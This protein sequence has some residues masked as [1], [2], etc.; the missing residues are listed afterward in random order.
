MIQTLI[1]SIVICVL[2]LD[3]CPIIGFPC[4]LHI[5][6]K[7]KG[8]KGIPQSFTLCKVLIFQSGFFYINL[9]TT[10]HFSRRIMIKCC[11]E[12]NFPRRHFFLLTPE[13]SVIYWLATDRPLTNS[14]SIFLSSSILCEILI[15]MM[16]K[17]F[18]KCL[19]FILCLP[20]PPLR[21]PAGSKVKSALSSLFHNFSDF[22]NFLRFPKY[23]IHT[24]IKEKMNFA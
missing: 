11:R 23:E 24:R 20:S 22:T 2:F 5:R 18:Y 7:R 8:A 4:L 12:Y 19:D 9:V 1:L 13:E 14:P 21:T 3:P 17:P 10:Q 16:R 6:S 15:K